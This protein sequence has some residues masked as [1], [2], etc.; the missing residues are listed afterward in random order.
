MDC[1]SLRLVK[2]IKNFPTFFSSVFCLSYLFLHRRFG[3]SSCH[4]VSC[5]SLFVVVVDDDFEVMTEIYEEF[6]HSNALDPDDTGKLTLR[7]DTVSAKWGQH[8]PEKISGAY[9]FPL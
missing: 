3:V 1:K 5:Q 6:L 9:R 4:L 7:E 8:F 2:E